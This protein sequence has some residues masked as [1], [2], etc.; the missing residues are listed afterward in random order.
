M[1]HFLEMKNILAIMDSKFLKIWFFP[2]CD[3]EEIKE[4]SKEI[5]NPN[6]NFDIEN[7]SKNT[8]I[9]LKHYGNTF[10]LYF[11]KEGEPILVIG[12]HCKIKFY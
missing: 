11:N 1:I 12:P 4:I 5:N 8:A 3:F 10:P 2:H 9:K 7:N 6:N